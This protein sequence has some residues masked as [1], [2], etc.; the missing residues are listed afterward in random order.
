M[1]DKSVEFYM[2]LPYDI[3]V[4]RK[5]SLLIL[6]ISELRLFAQDEN[7]DA[8]YRQL[9][10]EK[11]RFFEKH[12]EIDRENS[13]PQPGE[14]VERQKLAAG[15]TP[16]L[17]KAAVVALIL[18]GLAV[19]TTAAVTYSVKNTPLYVAQKTTRYMA[20]NFFRSMDAE[21]T[22]EREK[23]I[24]LALRQL[25]PRLKPFA[26]ELAP[27]FGCSERFTGQK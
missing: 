27:L 16:F 2:N 10:N 18:L 17:V 11:R 22:P 6:Y 3:T 7:L 12:L 25:V 5:D 14:L 19:G 9:D 24:R 13:I 4:I 23:K 15:L 21:L 26:A 1:N 20:R 8:A